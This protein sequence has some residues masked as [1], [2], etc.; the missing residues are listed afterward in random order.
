M[1]YIKI[2]IAYQIF[3]IKIENANQKLLIKIITAYQI[4]YIKIEKAH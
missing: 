1:L 3:Y 4:L 2:M